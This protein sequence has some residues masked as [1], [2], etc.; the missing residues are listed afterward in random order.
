MR[1]PPTVTPPSF[2]GLENDPMLIDLQ[3]Q[4]EER[5]IEAQAACEN[6]NASLQ[7]VADV[8]K[9]MCELRD[10]A[11]MLKEHNARHPQIQ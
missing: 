5:K 3:R 4:L 1:I 9:A 10:F 8:L 6:A 2:A 11:L 7:A